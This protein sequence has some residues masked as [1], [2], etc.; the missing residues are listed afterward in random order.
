MNEPITKIQQVHQKC[1]NKSEGDDQ[2]SRLAEFCDRALNLEGSLQRFSARA[3]I[4][5][6]L[7]NWFVAVRDN[8]KR[9]NSV[10]SPG[11][12]AETDIPLVIEELQSFLELT[13]NGSTS[14]PPENR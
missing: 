6:L 13:G 8:Q 9:E 11:S 3:A 4:A 14:K 5:E 2:Y 10:L 7:E 1:L 12:L